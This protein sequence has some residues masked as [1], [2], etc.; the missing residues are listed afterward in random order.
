MWS[1]LL[2]A[3]ALVMVIEG[4]MPFLAPECWREWLLQI[5]TIDARTL[6]VFGGVMI[7]IGLFL[8]NWVN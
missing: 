3:L 7:A 1:D 5:V 6:R 2:G 8:L 4:L